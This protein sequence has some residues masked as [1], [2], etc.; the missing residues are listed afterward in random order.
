MFESPLCLR[1]PL[2]LVIITA[3]LLEPTSSGHVEAT[4]PPAEFRSLR[5]RTAAYIPPTSRPAAQVQEG[6]PL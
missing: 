1:P 6:L 5:S 2:L 3:R 4:W